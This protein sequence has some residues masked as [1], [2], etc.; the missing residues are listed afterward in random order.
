M[1]KAWRDAHRAELRA[2]AAQWQKEHPEAVKRH[3]KTSY[4][5]RLP[6][7]L[8]QKHEAYIADPEKHRARKRAEFH[9]NALR[10]YG[11][12]ED[13]E[14][15]MLAAQG[16]VCA[17]CGTGEP[18]TK[19]GRWCRDHDHA[20]GR[21]RGLLCTSCNQGLGRF[22]DDPGVLLAAIRYLV[23]PK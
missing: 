22:R 3:N 7:I 9:R 5:R 10:R 4:E 13:D 12:T 16:G 21:L 14:A 8:K 6:A 20:T 15:A 1:S 19:Y 11:I 17:I 23:E 18:G 2:S